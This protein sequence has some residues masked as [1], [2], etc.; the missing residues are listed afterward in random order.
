MCFL[1]Q[2]VLRFLAPNFRIP[3]LRA[4]VNLTKYIIFPCV[5]Y[6][7]CR[8]RFNKKDNF[9][10]TNNNNFSF[11]YNKNTS[12]TLTISTGVTKY[13][14]GPWKSTD[15][16]S[17]WRRGASL[18]GMGCL[19]LRSDCIANYFQYFFGFV[20]NLI[21]DKVCGITKNIN[22][23]IIQLFINCQVLNLSR[24]RMRSWFKIGFF[25]QMFLSGYYFLG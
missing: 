4:L 2:I 12:L 15:W 9:T 22:L 1:D 23:V 25:S 6:T 11:L 13:L 8:Y 20:G 17:C 10:W 16:R 7:I 18:A 19:S 21:I 14:S 5:S 24:K 3:R